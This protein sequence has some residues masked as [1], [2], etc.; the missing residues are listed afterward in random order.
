M[1]FVSHLDM[2][3]FAARAVRRA[4]LPIWYTEGF[5]PHPY[6]TFALPL[7][8][9]MT[10]DYEVMDIRITDDEYDISCLC[11]KLNSVCPMYLNFFDAAEPRLKTGEL[12]FA[13]YE[14]IFDDNSMLER[15]LIQFLKGKEIFVTK[16]TKKGELKQLNAAEK[17]LRC[18][19]E[20]GQNTKLFITLPAGGSDNLNPEL[21][22][23][24]FFAEPLTD[25]FCYN[26]C[27][28]ALLDR[29]MNLF[30]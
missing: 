21:I 20:G 27:R 22:L 15:P 10:S 5:N 26:I 25:Y 11:E 12:A 13:D 19:V 7:S 17:I 18:R 23:T 30:K 6:I 29:D 14:I 28:T 24:A 3:R 1:K 4:H 9:G 16:K 2:T 8:L